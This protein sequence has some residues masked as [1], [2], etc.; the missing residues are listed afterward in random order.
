MQH[1]SPVAEAYGQIRVV[2]GKSLLLDL[3]SSE[4]QCVRLF[5]FALGDKSSH[6]G[7]CQGGTF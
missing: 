3:D 7:T 2:V 5:E 6:R 1:V 4:A